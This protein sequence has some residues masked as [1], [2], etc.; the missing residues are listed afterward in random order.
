MVLQSAPQERFLWLGKVYYIYGAYK[1]GE[2]FL[3]HALYCGEHAQDE[4]K[5]I[6]GAGCFYR[7]HATQNVY[8]PPDVLFRQLGKVGLQAFAGITGCQYS[9]KF[10]FNF[11]VFLSHGYALVG[12][13]AFRVLLSEQFHTVK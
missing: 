5:I 11:S 4:G 9:L 6:V 1:E 2:A 7:I 3:L 10:Y 13:A 8:G 12:K